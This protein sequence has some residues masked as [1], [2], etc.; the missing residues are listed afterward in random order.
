[1]TISSLNHPHNSPSLLGWWAKSKV[2]IGQLWPTGP[3]LDISEVLIRHGFVLICLHAQT[4]GL[5]T[6]DYENHVISF[7]PALCL[8]HNGWIQ[9]SHLIYRLQSMQIFAHLSS[10]LKPEVQSPPVF[11]LL[12]FVATPVQFFFPC[13][14]FWW[15]KLTFICSIC[16][17]YVLMTWTSLESFIFC[18]LENKEMRII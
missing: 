11:H 3:C 1:M 15:S 16:H 14:L 18:I 6:A 7:C 10:L 4:Q 5:Q 17:I 2:T 9:N 8:H 12:T 13:E